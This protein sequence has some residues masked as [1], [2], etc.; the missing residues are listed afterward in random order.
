MAFSPKSDWLWQTLYNKHAKF[1]VHDWIDECNT[2]WK[3]VLLEGKTL[4]PFQVVDRYLHHG[5]PDVKNEP[6]F[7][8]LEQ[9]RNAPP[10]QWGKL[11]DAIRFK[12]V[13]EHLGIGQEKIHIFRHEDCHKAY[14]FYSSP[15]ERAP[16]LM[17]TIEGGGDDSSATTSTMTADGA[18]TEHWKSNRVQAGRLYA[19]VT[20][21]LGGRS[22]DS[23]NSR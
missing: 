14:G 6:Y 9:A 5:G 12:T 13:R 22:L 21:I 3:P 11:G 20:L 4:S 10:E 1:S 7:P 16:A 8:F 18:I 19:Y 17:L 23:M 2:Y 15:R